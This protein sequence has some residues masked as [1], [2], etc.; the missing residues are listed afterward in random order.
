MTP[1]DARLPSGHN[2]VDAG[3][4][5]IDLLDVKEEEV[6][7]CFHTLVDHNEVAWSYYKDLSVS[8]WH[9]NEMIGDG[10]VTEFI[11]SL[12]ST[13]FQYNMRGWF[14]MQKHIRTHAESFKFF[15]MKTSGNRGFMMICRNCTKVCKISWS[16]KLKWDDAVLET[17]RV[18]LRDFLGF[19]TRSAVKRQRMV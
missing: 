14:D 4:L 19:G 1:F 11:Q 16:K 3:S 8:L 13:L 2:T 17:N 5:L 12:D 10:G 18:Q 7:E 6:E 15:R 9:G